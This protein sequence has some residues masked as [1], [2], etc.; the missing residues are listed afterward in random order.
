[1]KNSRKAYIP[2]VAERVWLVPSEEITANPDTP[3]ENWVPSG[4]GDKF[5]SISTVQA[6]GQW[7]W[8]EDGTI[9]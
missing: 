9:G 2:P 1:M 5:T 6:T 4:W 7:V 8:N 3:G